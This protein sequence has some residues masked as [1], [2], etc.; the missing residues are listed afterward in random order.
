MVLQFC[1][2][3]G[4]ESQTDNC[5]TTLA[6]VT[7]DISLS[8]PLQRTARCSPIESGPPNSLEM[9]IERKFKGF[10]HNFSSSFLTDHRQQEVRVERLADMVKAGCK[11]AADE[12]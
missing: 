8:Q 12:D 9:L 10:Y 7:P 5:N 6:V 2:S 3:R 11:D 1:P 4:E